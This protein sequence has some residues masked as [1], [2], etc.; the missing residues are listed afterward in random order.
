VIEFKVTDKSAA[1][2]DALETKMVAEFKAIRA[3]AVREMKARCVVSEKL[4][5]KY[6]GKALT[7]G[8][9]K[10]L[11]DTIH[12]EVKR[13]GVRITLK[14]GAAKFTAHFLELGTKRTP[15]HPFINPVVKALYAGLNSRIAA[16]A[17]TINL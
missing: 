16:A 1:F 6:H 15:A 10:H 13:D 8:D 14:A 9:A 4:R 2:L 12:A 3:E 11:R 5:L 17:A 7:E